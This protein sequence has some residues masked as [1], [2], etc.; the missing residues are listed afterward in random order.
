MKQFE[1]EFQRISYVSVWVEAE[2]KEQAETV[3]WENLN[4]DHYTKDAAWEINEIHEVSE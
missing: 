2:S 1:I 4:E 3:A